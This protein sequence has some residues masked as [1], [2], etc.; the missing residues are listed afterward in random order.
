V[1]K[2]IFIT[3]GVL[4]GL[5]KG[6]ST[7]AIGKILRGRGVKV[8]LC[9]IDPYLNVDP[10]LMNPYQHG[11]VWV[12]KDGYEADLDFG[13]YERFLD[14]ELERS[15]NITTG[16]IYLEVLE[17]ERRGEFLGQTVQIIP[18]ITDE[19]KRQIVEI[20]RIN[21]PDV[22][23]LEIGGTTGDIE[24]MPFL[25]ALRQMRMENG[26][27]NVLFIHVTLV[28]SLHAVG[29]QKTK[30]TQH[31]VKELR[32]IGIQPDILLC[33]TPLPLLDETRAKLALFCDVGKLDVISNHDLENIYRL[34]LVMEEQGLGDNILGKLNIRERKHDLKDWEK[35]VE[36]IEALE[37]T[38]R[39]AIVGKYTDLPDSYISIVEALKHGGYAVGVKVEV[40][41]VESVHLEEDPQRISDLD[42]V[43]G[44]L[45][46][47]GFGERG[48]E[49][50]ILAIHH[51]HT[52]G[53]P[54]LGICFG[55]QLGVVEYAR[56]ALGLKEA[57][58]SELDP[59]S[60]HPVIDLLPE[61]REV[62]QMG[63]TMRLGE[64]P[65]EIAEGTLA[66]RIYGKTQIAERHR[67]R[68][69]VNPEYIPLLEEQGLRFSAKSDGGRRM[70]ILELPDHPFFFA[71]QFHPEF[72]SRPQR[73]SPPFRAF[74]EAAMRRRDEGG[75]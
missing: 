27:D 66:H 28:P 50:K 51:A 54:F 6:V 68:Y 47:G 21:N 13:H 48:A 24:G 53:I 57:N 16:R 35:F 2:Y 23:L 49:G 58:S 73:P 59:E 45:V 67:H 30:P 17:K 69:E 3:G 44:I 26:K 72:K 19:I 18:H 31:S 63:G 20:S 14:I 5:G 37:E 65:L 34:P 64:L 60:P 29:E 9:K 56:S 43:S 75:R 40:Q 22:L 12:T 25:E 52:H 8:D 55:F 38:V 62:K 1:T 10:G 39:I 11:E 74:V 42:G 33:R 71:T 32:G 46:P 36:R 41:W 15:H 4:S 70:E 61:Q 7:A